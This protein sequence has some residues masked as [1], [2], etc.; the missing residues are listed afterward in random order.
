MT[1]AEAEAIVVACVQR[2]APG[3]DVL[4]IPPDVDMRRALDLDSMDFLG[5]VELLSERTGVQIAEREYARVQSRQG[6][7]DYLVAAGQ[8]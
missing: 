6:M 5:L 3:A 1:P 8:A 7:V 2:I 4:G